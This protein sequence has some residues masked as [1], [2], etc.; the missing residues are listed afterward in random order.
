[1]LIF[2][3]DS[4]DW[5]YTMG[6][7]N[8][9]SEGK[10]NLEHGDDTSRSVRDIYEANVELAENRAK[11]MCKDKSLCCNQVTILHQN[12]VRELLVFTKITEK[13]VDVINCQEI[14]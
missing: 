11:E 1:M 6:N 4:S 9:F 5:I 7:I 12:A 8:A 2:L 13:T 3:P 14:K 10:L